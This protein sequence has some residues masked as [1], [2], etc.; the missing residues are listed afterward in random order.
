MNEIKIRDNLI[1]K[2]FN[3]LTA[4]RPLRKNK[5]NQTIWNLLCDCGNKKMQKLIEY[6]KQI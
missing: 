4:L 6:R 3:K 5:F 2:K 1:G